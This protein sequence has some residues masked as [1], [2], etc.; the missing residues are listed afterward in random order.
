[1]HGS[2]L[3]ESACPVAISLVFSAVGAVPMSILMRVDE[4]IK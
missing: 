3:L 2:D 1:M 4:L